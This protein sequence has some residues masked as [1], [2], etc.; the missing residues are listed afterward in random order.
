MEDKER[1]IAIVFAQTL[2]ALD[3]LDDEEYISCDDELENKILAVS[4]IK[5]SIHRLQ[6]YVEQVIPAYDNEQ[7]KSHFRY[8]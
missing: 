6:N 1:I 2:I 5:K 4:R 7:F 3:C 8:V